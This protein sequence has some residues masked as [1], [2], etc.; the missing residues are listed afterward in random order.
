MCSKQPWRSRLWHPRDRQ[1]PAAK[2]VPGSAHPWPELALALHLAACRQG[3]HS[4]HRRP[5]VLPGHPAP[6]R[7]EQEAPGHQIHMFLLSLHISRDVCSVHPPPGPP[8]PLH[9]SKHPAPLKF[10]TYT[11][12]IA[13]LWRQL[14]THYKKEKK[15]CLGPHL[16]LLVVLIV[17]QERGTAALCNV[18][19][20]APRAAHLRWDRPCK[21]SQ[22]FSHPYERSQNSFLNSEVC[23][24]VSEDAYNR[25]IK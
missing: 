12:K 10:V 18:A 13:R 1:T 7:R 3:C 22:S 14:T 9:T 2:A 21:V 15:T 5:W 24:Y 4:P 6:S 25:H 17:T 16:S 8:Q 20:P 19:V 23:K 11:N